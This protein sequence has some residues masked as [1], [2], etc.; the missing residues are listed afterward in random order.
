MTA[1]KERQRTL[2]L[3]H[4]NRLYGQKYSMWIP[5]HDP[6]VWVFSKLLAQIWRIV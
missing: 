3:D 1:I 6:H 5:D 2:T 4:V